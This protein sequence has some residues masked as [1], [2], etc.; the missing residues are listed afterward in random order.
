M[1]RM[2]P[3]SIIRST[4]KTVI[5]TSGTGRTVFATVRCSGEFGT[6]VSTPP[7]QRTVANMVR[8]VPDVVITVLSV[9]L[10]MDEG[11]IRNM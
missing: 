2:I 7:R 4:L 9:L 11:I 3:S 1:F 5:T 8:T 6:A 10:M